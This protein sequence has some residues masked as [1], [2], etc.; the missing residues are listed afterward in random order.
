[1]NDN[2]KNLKL[3]KQPIAQI[4]SERNT[5]AIRLALISM[6]AQLAEAKQLIM[7]QRGTIAM[8]VQ[9]VAHLKQMEQLRK[10]NMTGLGPSVKE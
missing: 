7:S 2:V 3:V 9:D 8:L 4:L 1:M 5:E 6:E 10:I